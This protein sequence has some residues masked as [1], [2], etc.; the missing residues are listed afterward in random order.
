MKP[1]VVLLSLGLL[2]AV[3]ALG[4]VLIS[5]SRDAGV[6]AVE[7]HASPTSG[8]AEAAVAPDTRSAEVLQRLDALSREVDELREQL[9]SVKASASREPAQEVAA[10]PATS[11]TPA[12]YSSERRGEILKVIEE[13]REAQKRKAEEEQRAR[14]L[15]QSLQRAERTAKQFG[16]AADQQK[17]L[18]D[19]YILERQ[20]MEEMRN[21]FRDQGMN[22]DP[23]AM[24]TSFREMRDWRMNELTLKLGAELAEKINDSDMAA[25]RGFGGGGGGGR[26]GNRGGGNDSGNGG[27][28]GGNRPG[29][30][31]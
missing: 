1:A 17:A 5:G 12:S 23:E 18:A 8:T 29:G 6:H 31:F 15:Q 22:G 30:G 4:V 14:D 9:A 21:Q 27:T 7:T 26:R 3:G 28:D 10:I 20:K 13:D 2:L 25:F 11:D 19:V 24:R 16:L